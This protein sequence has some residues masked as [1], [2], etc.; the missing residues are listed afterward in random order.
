M[1]TQNADSEVRWA[2]FRRKDAAAHLKYVGPEAVSGVA[3]FACAPS[4]PRGDAVTGSEFGQDLHLRIT[5]CRK[6]GCLESL[7]ERL[8]KQVD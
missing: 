3:C 7:P 2:M 1:N 8:Q 4:A 6:T 5:I